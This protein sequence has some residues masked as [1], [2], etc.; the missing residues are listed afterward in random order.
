MN[1][2]PGAG[3]AFLPAAMLL[4]QAEMAVIVT[5]RRTNLLYVNAYALR[6]L[7]VA[8]EPGSFIGRSVLSLGFSQDQDKVTELAGSVL[9]GRTWE[10]TFVSP[11]RD[12]STRLIRA[13]AVP[14]RHPSG[15]ID[16]ICIFARKAG[17]G[18]LAERHRIG[19]LERIGQKLG[20]SLGTGA[21]PGPVTRGMGPHVRPALHPP[22][23]RRTTRR[24]PPTAGGPAA[25]STWC[26]WSPCRCTPGV[27]SWA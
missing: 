22:W 10:G 4:D 9:H 11:R 6:L 12:G 3:E 13:Y 8:G 14:L 19:L 21:T 20:G 2:W 16:G 17:R 15:A 26:R 27:S 24:P 5:D 25:K 18:S 1:P 23:Q 7:D